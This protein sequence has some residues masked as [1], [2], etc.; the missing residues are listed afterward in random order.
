MINEE[1]RN[2]FKMLSKKSE[3]I[4]KTQDFSK[5]KRLLYEFGFG[6][7]EMYRILNFKNEKNGKQNQKK[8]KLCKKGRR[9][10]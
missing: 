2:F 6:Y 10:N 7:W 9:K 8:Q 3:R 5:R 1:T 4:K